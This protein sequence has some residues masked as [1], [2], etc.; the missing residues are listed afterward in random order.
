MQTIDEG[1][2]VEIPLDS[3]TLVMKQPP[4]LSSF[5]NASSSNL[6]KP[7][8]I[9]RMNGVSETT[10]GI[11]QI[12]DCVHDNNKYN[13]SSMT[14][15]ALPLYDIFGNKMSLI[16][17][18]RRRHSSPVMPAHLKLEVNKHLPTP[19][20]LQPTPRMTASS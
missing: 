17:N 6:K 9:G 15:A 5:E 10:G 8:K 1:D 2:L 13:I 18:K 19:P 20:P 12:T 16:N 14:P 3:P 4:S 11:H 7:R